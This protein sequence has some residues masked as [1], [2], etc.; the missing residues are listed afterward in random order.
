MYVRTYVIHT[1]IRTYIR[2]YLYMHTYT[3]ISDTYLVLDSTIACVLKG[4]MSTVT[5]ST[6]SDSF[7]TLSFVVT[8]V[9]LFDDDVV[10]VDTV[11][12][13]GLSDFE[14][15]SLLT[16]SSDFCV[17]SVAFSFSASSFLGSS[18]VWSSFGGSS[19]LV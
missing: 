1:Y 17:S 19:E 13:D 3:Y 8:L 11:S 2:M 15:V 16:G 10:L 14:L 4:V 6:S 12:F 5:I 7:T 9:V 18:V